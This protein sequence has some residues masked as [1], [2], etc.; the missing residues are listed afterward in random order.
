M[1]KILYIYIYIYIYTVCSRL[2]KK[3]TAISLDHMRKK[4]NR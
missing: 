3:V 2:Q 4:F 1:M